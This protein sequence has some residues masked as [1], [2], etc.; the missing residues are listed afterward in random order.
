MARY[1]PSLCITAVAMTCIIGC[2]STA[3]SDHHT[4]STTSTTTANST[5]AKTS[6]DSMTASTQAT[7]SQTVDA[8]TTGITEISHNVATQVASA[9]TTTDTDATGLAV[10][11]I[12]HK[13]SPFN[14]PGFIVEEEE[15]LLW[16][17]RPGQEKSDKAISLIS[18]GPGGKTVRAVDRETAMEYIATR[19][20]FITEVEEGRLWVLKPGQEKSDKHTTIVGQ[21]P[22]GMTVKAADRDTI[23][24][25]LAA[26]PGF[27]TMVRDGRVWVL[28]Y[29]EKPQDKHVTFVA[30]GPLGMTVKAN[31]RDLALAYFAAA[32][33]FNTEIE[34][35]RIWV[36]APGEKKADKHITRI[37]AG[38]RGMTV[39]GVSADTLNR[40][41]IATHD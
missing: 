38:P 22:M 6:V 7:A 29:D 9:A 40:Y 24:E 3:K 16:V 31:D 15:G 32:E 5:T 37:K 14:K 11:T 33:G 2:E 19:P 34:E 13:T 1:L 39:K 21:G 30:A 25:Y 36:L 12:S 35:G 41:A 28:D 27:K 26:K 17:R 20:G 4:A 23:I 18:Q 10:N 8:A